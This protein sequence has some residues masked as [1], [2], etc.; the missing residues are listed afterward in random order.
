MNILKAQV[1]RS[2][3]G[4]WWEIQLLDLE[5]VADGKNEQEML[6]ELEYRLTV[7]YQLAVKNQ[8]TP[9]VKLIKGDPEKISTWVQGDKKLRQL[10]LPAEVSQA[11]SAIF[12]APNLLPFGTVAA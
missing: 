3:N 2:S 11:L 7:E 9:F 6:D 10:K 1:Q 5:I 12:R 4:Q 8:E